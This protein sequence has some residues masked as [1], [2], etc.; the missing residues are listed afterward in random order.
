MPIFFFFFHSLRVSYFGENSNM[1]RQGVD[2]VS[3]YEYIQS[4]NNMLET[5]KEESSEVYVC[6]EDLELLF[7]E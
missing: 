1:I 6:L 3:L 5:A 4:I 2:K 7:F